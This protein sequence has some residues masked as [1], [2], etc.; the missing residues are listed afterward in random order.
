MKVFC[1]NCKFLHHN[2]FDYNILTCCAT[3]E[4]TI[5]DPIVGE[6][7]LNIRAIRMHPVDR[8]QGFNCK[9][10]KRSFWKF[11]VKDKKEKETNE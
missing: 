9:Y 8:N 1:K 4:H 7:L 10:Y 2:F 3:Y 11:W 5:T 6:R